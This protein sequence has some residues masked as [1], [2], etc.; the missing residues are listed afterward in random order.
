MRH[1][2][3]PDLTRSEP[4]CHA[5]PHLGFTSSSCGCPSPRRETPVRTAREVL[6]RASFIAALAWAGVSD[7]HASFR[8]AAT[9]AAAA[10][11][12]RTTPPSLE[13]RRSPGA[14]LGRLD[15]GAWG[16]RGPVGMSA[17]R[18]AAPT[19]SRTADGACSRARRGRTL[20][21]G[22]QHARRRARARSPVLRRARGRRRSRARGSP[23][24]EDGGAPLGSGA[25]LGSAPCDDA[26]VP[27]TTGADMSGPSNRHLRGR[28]N[29]KARPARLR[30]GVVP[31]WRAAP[32]A[33]PRSCSE[34]ERARRARP[35]AR[36]RASEP[37]AAARRRHRR[38]AP[39]RRR[40]RRGPRARRARRRS[41]RCFAPPP[42]GAA[43]SRPDR[44]PLVQVWSP[45]TARRRR[46]RTC[47]TFHDRSATRAAVPAARFSISHA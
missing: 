21:R 7:A 35:T 23:M 34:R 33:R 25:A 11:D 13:H 36:H 12:A 16:R 32:T 37:S 20:T 29:A 15:G 22:L 45:S 5:D 30:P 19:G 41:A 4:P 1:S 24:S 31:R 42:S 43:S 6:V 40:A 44:E 18:Q 9:E 17:R 3:F 38:R 28:L 14:S 27:R 47:V 39:H 46:R 10:G 8:P 2:K 26:C